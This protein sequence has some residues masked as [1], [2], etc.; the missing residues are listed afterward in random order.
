MK[1]KERKEN[2][3]IAPAKAVWFGSIFYPY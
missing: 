2:Q 3:S 1:E